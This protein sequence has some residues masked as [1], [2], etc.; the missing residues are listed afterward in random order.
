MLSCVSDDDFEGVKKSDEVTAAKMPSLRKIPSRLKFV[1]NQKEQFT[2]RSALL[3]N[4]LS[5]LK[6]AQKE[7]LGLL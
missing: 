4:R 5:P 3:S 1:Q 7:N 2:N 6:K